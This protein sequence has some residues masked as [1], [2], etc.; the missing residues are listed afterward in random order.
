[1]AVDGHFVKIESIKTAS[2]NL[3]LRNH[4]VPSHAKLYD[5]HRQGLKLFPVIMNRYTPLLIVAADHSLIPQTPR[6][7]PHSFSSYRF[8]LHQCLQRKAASIKPTILICR[9]PRVMLPWAVYFYCQFKSFRSSS[10]NRAFSSSD[11]DTFNRSMVKSRSAAAC[12]T[13]VLKSSRL[14]LPFIT[15]A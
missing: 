12:S 4:H 15:R 2:E 8:D 11:F 6:T 1:M 14:M 10:I 9:P 13:P 7:V 3:P 5:F